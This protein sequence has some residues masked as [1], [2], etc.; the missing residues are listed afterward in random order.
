MLCLG[1]SL[2]QL[3]SRKIR[4]LG[5]TDMKLYA[6]EAP[7]GLLEERRRLGHDRF[8]EMWEGVVHMNA[9]PHR[10]HQVLGS[11]LFVW[12]YLHWRRAPQ[13][14][15]YPERNIAFPGG[16]P[17]D[18]RIPDLVL[19]T[20]ERSV[21]D[22]G[23]YIEGPPL[24]CIEIHSPH[25]EAYEKLEFYARLEVP[26]VWIIDRDTKDVELYV[27]KSVVKNFELAVPG[28]DGWL[29]SNATGILL[30]TEDERLAI[31]LADDVT[32]RTDLP[33]G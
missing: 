7:P 33:Q 13:H 28:S 31:Q 9:V 27:L 10:D 17:N 12:L 2:L 8:D 26:E 11:Q 14:E 19:T 25:D 5:N 15:V 22:R 16:W 30:K 23:T 18:Y 29:R 3:I 21:Y 24:V 6:A 1:E 20:A 4:R 32:S